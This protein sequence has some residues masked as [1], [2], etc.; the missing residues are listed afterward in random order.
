MKYLLDTDTCI[1]VFKGNERVI[2]RI[3]QVSGDELAVSAITC[4]ELIYGV[5]RCARE[6]QAKEL[7]KVETFLRHIHTL[8]FSVETASH[9]AE[10]RRKLE[11]KGVPIGP[12][13]TLIAATA[14]EAG[15]ILVTGNIREFGRIEGLRAESWDR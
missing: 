12:M 8:P 13:D 6:R 14:M 11:E 9:A 5:K 2:E 7:R 4:Y 1:H 3:E 10:I 15:L